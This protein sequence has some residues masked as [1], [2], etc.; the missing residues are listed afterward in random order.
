MQKHVFA[1]AGA[2]SASFP[3]LPKNGVAVVPMAYPYELAWDEENVRPYIQNYL[4]KDFRRGNPAGNAIVSAIDLIRLSNAMHS[5]LI[6]KPETFRTHTTPKFELNTDYGYGFFSKYGNRPFTGHGGN[7][8]GTCTEF[9]ELR[10]TPY[11]IVVLSNLKMNVCRQVTERILRVLRPTEATAK[12]AQP[13][14]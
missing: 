13:P 1:P 12:P 4:G 10:D 5:G 6:V 14:E 7:A 11:T 8:M 3:L 9:G 2:T